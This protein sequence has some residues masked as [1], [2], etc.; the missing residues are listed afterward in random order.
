MKKEG[1]GGKSSRQLFTYNP[2]PA[3]TPDDYRTLKYNPKA[4]LDASQMHVDG[5]TAAVARPSAKPSGARAK[6]K[7]K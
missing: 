3:T 7:R 4:R 5:T 2:K 6:P 1:H